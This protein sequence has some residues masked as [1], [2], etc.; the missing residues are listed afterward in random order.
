MKKL[1]E[2]LKENPI[3]AVSAVVAVVCFGLVLYFLLIA[4]SSLTSQIV[5]DNEKDA[6]TLESLQ[7]GTV[8]LPDPDP[9]N[10]PIVQSNLVINEAVIERI[11][12]IYK[13][14]GDQQLFI[15]SETDRINKQ[16]H[17]GKFILAFDAIGSAPVSGADRFAAA[18]Q[19]KKSFWVMFNGEA[20]GPEV[21]QLGMP[22]FRA[23]PPPPIEWIQLTQERTVRDYLE[24]LGASSANALDEKQAT[25]LFI[26]Q[27][28]TLMNL[29][30]Q[31]AYK[32]DFYA[33]L[34]QVDLAEL[35]P[36]FAEQPGTTTGTTTPRPIV[37]PGGFSI[38]GFGEEGGGTPA[39]NQGQVE[40]YGPFNLAAWASADSPPS[41]EQLWEGQVE[42]WI[43]RDL[44]TTVA[45]VNKVGTTVTL[46]NADGE[47]IEMPQN[48]VTAPIKRLVDITVVP[49]Y[50]GLHTRGGMAGPGGQGND[51]LLAP[52]SS[53]E[54]VDPSYEEFG[55]EE[56]GP[57]VL[58]GPTPGGSGTTTE[59]PQ[60][61]YP[62]PAV[63]TLPEAKEPLEANFFFGPTGRRS[64]SIYDVRHVWMT[65]HIQADRLPEFFETL[66]RVNFMT[67]INMRVTD[68]D[69]YDMLRQGFV[70]GDADVVQVSLTIETLWFRTWTS[71]YMPDIVKQRLVV[72][73]EPDAIA[74]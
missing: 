54:L 65:M 50:V 26:Q 56:F 34:P 43:I 28:V 31:W 33:D 42:L 67:V 2:W 22:T 40:R 68:V 52:A 44:M 51:V 74:E 55:G 45:R 8:S 35:D 9:N 5:E 7:R 49:Y 29:L 6:S 36:I 19:Y 62:M 20:Y 37:E 11:R 17:E 23:G 21:P 24:S 59:N 71:D 47:M 46:P 30:T 63:S 38:P 73:D 72:A 25:D 15:K 39:A 53:G 27:R 66:R 69:E 32:L 14:I 61:V 3:S 41:L 13:T 60:S 16:N 18:D 64:N 1:L 48:V 58:P 70:Y 57:G 10:P 12:D 4:S